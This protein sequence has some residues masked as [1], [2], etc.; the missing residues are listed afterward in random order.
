MSKIDPF[1]KTLKR[2]AR[3]NKPPA[4]IS[5][6]L[7]QDNVRDKWESRCSVK[8]NVQGKC[9]DTQPVIGILTQ[10]VAASK[11]DK[12][13]YR[14]Y[15]LEVNDNFVKWAGSRTIT[16][17]YDIA[18][19]DLIKLLSQ[20]NG[21]LFTGGGLDLIDPKTGKQHPYYVTAKKIY[22]YSKYMKDA[23]KEEWPILGIC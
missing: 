11:K 9:Y 13:N 7:L 2:L 14:D 12:F 18:E 4:Q 16:I 8:E 3:F 6:E 23:R 20:I 5:K 1:D 17:P 19:E 22:T 21:V 10:P 15:I